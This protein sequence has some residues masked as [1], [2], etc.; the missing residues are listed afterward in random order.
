MGNSDAEALEKLRAELPHTPVESIPITALIDAFGEAAAQF[1]V[2]SDEYRQALRELRDAQQKLYDA[3]RWYLDDHI[4]MR[5]YF[6]SVAEAKRNGEPPKVLALPAELRE[7]GR[8]LHIF[9]VEYQQTAI[10]TTQRELEQ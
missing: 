2:D 3:Y 10:D 6:N 1:G 7:E 5:R 9:E 8:V 4:L